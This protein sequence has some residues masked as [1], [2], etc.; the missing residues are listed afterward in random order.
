[1]IGRYYANLTGIVAAIAGQAMRFT[2]VLYADA[3]KQTRCDLT[4]F[5][6]KCTLVDTAGAV[7]VA[8]TTANNGITLSGSAGLIS[9][10]SSGISPAHSAISAGTHTYALELYNSSGVLELYISGQWLFDVDL[11][12]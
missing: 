5:T 9:V 3:L 2:T 1:M 6:A 8:A 4:G 7:L 12:P 11:S 10:D